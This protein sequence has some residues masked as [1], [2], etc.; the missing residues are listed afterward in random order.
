MNKMNIIISKWTKVGLLLALVL[1]ISCYKDEGNY[2]LTEINK[3][4][5]TASESD[6]LQINQFDT[7]VV[8]PVL[9][10]SLEDNEDNLTYKWSVYLYSAPITGL[11]DEVLAETRDL[12]V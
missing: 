12:E 7:L 2:D 5:I 11:I 3:V 4:T 1:Q 8:R 10:Q 9:Q 6:T